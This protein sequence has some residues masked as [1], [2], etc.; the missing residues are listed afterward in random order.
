M[1]LAKVHTSDGPEGPALSLFSMQGERVHHLNLPHP[2][3]LLEVSLKK[4]CKIWL[5]NPIVFKS[6]HFF[7]FLSTK[8]QFFVLADRSTV[9]FRDIF[10]L[11]EVLPP[12]VPDPS[13]LGITYVQVAKDDMVVLI[14]TTSGKVLSFYYA[15]D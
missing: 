14:G 8:I 9:S 7:T 3:I 6:V 10:T 11:Q 5:A 13:L 12:Y 4:V 1:F 2:L 15:N